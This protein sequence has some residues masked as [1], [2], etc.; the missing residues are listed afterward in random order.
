M[1]ESS[2]LLLLSE[3]M[4]QKRQDRYAGADYSNRLAP[5]RRRFPEVMASLDALRMDFLDQHKLRVL[6]EALRKFVLL[7]I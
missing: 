6:S 3:R 2:D 1:V 7:R 5:Y 4:E